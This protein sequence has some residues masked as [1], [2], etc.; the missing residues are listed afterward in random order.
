MAESASASSAAR[1]SEASKPAA[2][3]F[4]VVT[5]TPPHPS[6][7]DSAA[8]KAA[9][10]AAPVAASVAVEMETP[11]IDP[12][13]SLGGTPPPGTRVLLTRTSSDLFI[14]LPP[15][16]WAKATLGFAFFSV[17][18]L[19]PLLL[20]LMVPDG[21]TQEGDPMP[22]FMPVVSALC[23]LMAALSVCSAFMVRTI[24]IDGCQLLHTWQLFGWSAD[25]T[26]PTASIIRVSLCKMERRFSTMYFC[27]VSAAD[28][29]QLEF[30]GHLSRADNT[31]MQQEVSSFLLGLGA[32][33]I[34]AH[35]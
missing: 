11:L 5:V 30:G 12:S 32:D 7:V 29:K 22:P 10:V 15:L 1:G 26:I 17:L 33:S 24:R 3:S 31:W 4:S 21:A 23:S 16:H 19:L 18:A 2:S 20:P 6:G 8:S 25:T 35:D 27:R 34:T 14:R 9:S 13:H 28:G